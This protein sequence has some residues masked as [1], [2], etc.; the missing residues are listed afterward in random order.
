MSSDWDTWAARAER[1]FAEAREIDA[2]L[3]ELQREAESVLVGDDLPAVLRLRERAEALELRSQRY[4]HHVYR[5][6]K[7][8][9]R[10][11]GMARAAGVTP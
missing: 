10:L 3:E 9:M 11:P 2:A 5:Q 7:R 6:L 8:A 4:R 1:D